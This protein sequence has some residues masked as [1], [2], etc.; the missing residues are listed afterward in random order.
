MD[1]KGAHDVV[2]GT[3]ADMQ[4]TGEA[5]AICF[6]RSLSTSGVLYLCSSEA[7]VTARGGT[8][9]PAPILASLTRLHP[10]GT[11]Q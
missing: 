6:A 4:R 7:Q 11:W 9:V 2:H 1:V 10:K 3:C 5:S 8:R